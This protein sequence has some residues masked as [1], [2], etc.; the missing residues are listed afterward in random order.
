MRVKLLK[1][2][3]FFWFASRL[4]FIDNYFKQV[5]FIKYLLQHVKL[6]NY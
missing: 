5:N 2:Y 1:K 6:I 3:M 4:I